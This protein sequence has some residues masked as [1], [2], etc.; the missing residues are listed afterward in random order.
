MEYLP[1]VRW[2][3]LCRR[4]TPKIN[5]DLISENVLRKILERDPIRQL[6]IEVDQELGLRLIT[7]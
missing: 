1:L 5:T 7:L 4:Q 2:L 3:A 6:L